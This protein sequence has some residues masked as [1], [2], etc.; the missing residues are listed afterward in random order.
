VRVPVIEA[1]PPLVLLHLPT[2]VEIDT[3]NRQV[4]AGPR[5]LMPRQVAGDILLRS[6]YGRPAALEPLRATTPA[7]GF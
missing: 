4:S 6:V 5:C 1:L 2:R 7:A 3:V